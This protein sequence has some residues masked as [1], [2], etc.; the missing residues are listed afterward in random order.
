MGAALYLPQCRTIRF[1]V[2]GSA[3]GICNLLAWLS[4]DAVRVMA[5]PH[6]LMSDS[7]RQLDRHISTGQR[8]ASAAT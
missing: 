8:A 7:P 1:G 2:W 6:T 3:L 4:L 5:N